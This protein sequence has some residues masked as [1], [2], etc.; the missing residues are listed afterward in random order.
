MEN[1]GGARRFP[2][3]YGFN[4]VSSYLPQPDEGWFPDPT[5]M[6]PSLPP[7]SQ[8]FV[9]PAPLEQVQPAADAASPAVSATAQDTWRHKQRLHTSDALMSKIACTLLS[10]MLAFG[11]PAMKKRN[12]E[13]NKA[14]NALIAV[15]Q[16]D[17]E[18]KALTNGVELKQST[19]K[20]WIDE[21]G[22][23]LAEEAVKLANKTGEAGSEKISGGATKAQ[24]DWKEL[25]ERFEALNNPVP[26]AAKVG[27]KLKSSDTQAADKIF[28]KASRISGQAEREVAVGKVMQRR[29]EAEA[30]ET[31]EE[32]PSGDG[33]SDP[34]PDAKDK[35]SWKRARDLQGSAKSRDSSFAKLDGLVT[36]LSTAFQ[37]YGATSA[38]KAQ[39]DADDAKAKLKDAEA[40]VLDAEARREEAQ[41][42]RL[43]T[44]SKAAFSS[45]ELI[46]KMEGLL[47]RASSKS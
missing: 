34:S 47:E 20:K 29:Q 36:S 24:L 31:G 45:I 10:N 42:K 17:A 27:L 28:A 30:S 19:V 2:Q 35:T 41:A 23:K 16:D 4:F 37:N 11:L 8:Q 18:C 7:L 22:P 15:L 21:D 12:H 43:K 1:G 39:A 6:L 26:S 38:I 33:S 25:M 9:Q 13:R 44:E 14:L 32:S 5:M 40:K 3:S 46:E